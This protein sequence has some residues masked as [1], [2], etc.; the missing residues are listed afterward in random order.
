M[1]AAFEED[2]NLVSPEHPFWK[3]FSSRRTTADAIIALQKMIMVF[4]H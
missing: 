3:E 4:N 1:V 2:G